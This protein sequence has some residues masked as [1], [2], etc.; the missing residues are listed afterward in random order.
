MVKMAEHKTQEEKFCSV[1]LSV[2][3]PGSRVKKNLDPG[4]GS[5]SKS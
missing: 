2:V 1:T 4:S 5:V 3:D